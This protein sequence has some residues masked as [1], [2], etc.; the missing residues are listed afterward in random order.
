VSVM[1][2]CLDIESLDMESLELE[3][4]WSLSPF[5]GRILRSREG[6]NVPFLEMIAIRPDAKTGK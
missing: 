3:R 6:A 1:W 4:P 5:A 2:H